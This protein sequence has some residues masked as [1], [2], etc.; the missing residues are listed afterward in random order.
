[1]RRFLIRWLLWHG[2][3]WAVIGTLLAPVLPGGALA[4][5][6][7]SLLAAAPILVLVRRFRARGGDRG[8]YPRR[9][10]RLLV[11]RPFWYGQVAAPVLAAAGLAGALTGWPFG[12]AGTA[13]RVGLGLAG[14]ILLM[15]GI[16]GW[17]GSHRLR[18]TRLGAS[19][20]DL[21][22]ALDGLT[23]AQ[24]SDLH[25]GPHVSRT[26]LA[27]VRRMIDGTRADLVVVTGDLVDDF[28]R[29]VDVYAAAFGDLSAPL[30]VWVSPGNHDV[31]AGWADVRTRLERLPLTVLVNESRVLERG[32]ARL[33]IVGLGDPAGRHWS[34]EGG[35]SAAPDPSRALRAVPA[36]AFTI[37]L[38]H[39]PALWP[40][41]AARGA[42]LT[43]SGH[44]H[45]GQLAHPAVAWSLASHFLEHAMGTAARGDSLLYIHPG[46]GYWGIPFR[47]GAWP[48][49]ALITLRRGG[50][51]PA[52]T[53][54]G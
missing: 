9:T 34:R 21:P 3:V 22:E 14:L 28:A 39:N 30:G 38:A 52:W 25:V 49:V 4:A 48:E 35:A 32:G 5:A 40:D 10:M 13:G 12:I 15:I 7:L 50:V 44:T 42:R 53:R 46:T 8:Y 26:F 47:I 31:Y 16:A 45:W 37:A 2:T 27:R 43:L 19:W 29:D 1:M 54:E 51:E 41:L 17:L 36:D 11:L 6:M 18:L 24:V 33:A 20:Q 23:I